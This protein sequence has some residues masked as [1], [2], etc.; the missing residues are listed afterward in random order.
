MFYRRKTKRW[1]RN[2][3]EIS[4]D[5]LGSHW[6]CQKPVDKMANCKSVCIMYDE[7]KHFERTVYNQSVW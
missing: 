1:E 4:S 5:D 7:A 3:D 6:K 2:W